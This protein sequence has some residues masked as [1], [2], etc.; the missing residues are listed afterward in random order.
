[1]GNDYSWKFGSPLHFI[2]INNCLEDYEENNSG[3]TSSDAQGRESQEN[4]SNKKEGKTGVRE[5]RKIE[6]L[7][8]YQSKYE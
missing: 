6:Q 1:M 8:G 3:E 2:I 4:V 7:E 5:E